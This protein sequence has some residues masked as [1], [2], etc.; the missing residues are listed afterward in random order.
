MKRITLLFNG[1]VL[2]DA[3]VSERPATR[4]KVLGILHETIAVAVDGEP[5]SIFM[6]GTDRRVLELR[7]DRVQ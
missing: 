2:F 7:I 6:D 4:D 5:A 1:Y 3:L